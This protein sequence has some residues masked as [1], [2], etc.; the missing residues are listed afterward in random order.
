MK[1]YALYLLLVC[2]FVIGCQKDIGETDV[3]LKSTKDKNCN[4]C[5]ALYLPVTNTGHL[6]YDSIVFNYHDKHGNL[7]SIRTYNRAYPPANIGLDFIYDKNNKVSRVQLYPRNE[8]ILV[9][10]KANKIDKCEQYYV[11]QSGD[12]IP[13]KRW[14]FTWNNE[15]LCKLKEFDFRQNS[16]RTETFEYKSNTDASELLSIKLNELYDDELTSIVY[17]DKNYWAKDIKNKELLLVTP[18]KFP[19]LILPIQKEISYSRFYRDYVFSGMDRITRLTEGDYNEAGY[20]TRVHYD[21]HDYYL[22]DFAPGD[23]DD[24]STTYRISYNKVIIK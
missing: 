24:W 10:Y 23:N 11:N 18:F 21:D 13:T 20:P 16:E 3:D 4:K 17:S 2:F 9:G 1:N 14:T 22:G 19:D 8:F 6:L 15:V 7:S 5:K 12:T